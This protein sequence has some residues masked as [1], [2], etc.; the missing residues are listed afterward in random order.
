MNSR[1]LIVLL[2]GWSVASLAGYSEKDGVRVRTHS[3]S[4]KG[5]LD[6]YTTADSGKTYLVVDVEVTNRTGQKLNFFK[7][8]FKIKDADGFEYSPGYNPDR[9]INGGVLEN[10]DHVRGRLAFEVPFNSRGH[11]LIFG[12]RGRDEITIDAR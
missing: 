7:W 5:A 11:K 12:P 2:L 1:W 4:K 9:D 6:A 8:D 10:G 3:V